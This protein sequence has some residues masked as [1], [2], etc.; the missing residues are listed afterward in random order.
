MLHQ[1]RWDGDEGGLVSEQR[2]LGC[3]KEDKAG[4]AARPDG[5][6]CKSPANTGQ[7]LP[8]GAAQQRALGGC[9]TVETGKDGEGFPAPGHL[10]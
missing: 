2:L 3:V 10:R 7:L 9:T 8:R 1:G 6:L 5:A 4:G